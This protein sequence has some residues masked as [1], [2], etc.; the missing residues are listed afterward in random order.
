[1]IPPTAA[2]ATPNVSFE[3]VS[4]EDSFDQNPNHFT[5][6]RSFISARGLGPCLGYLLL[7]LLCL[8]LIVAE[9]WGVWI[10][11]DLM[12]HAAVHQWREWH[13]G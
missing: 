5:R 11:C 1:M 2:E 13:H 12:S 6:L 10:I 8:G 4:F 9:V 3:D 7:A